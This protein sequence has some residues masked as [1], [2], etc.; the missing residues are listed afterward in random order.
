M[1]THMKVKVFRNQQMLPKYTL[2][3]LV[4]QSCPTLCDAIDGSLQGSPVPGILQARI[5]EWVAM[6]FSRGSSQPRGSNP[7]LLHCRQI[8][9]PLSYREV[10]YYQFFLLVDWYSKQE[11]FILFIYLT[12]LGLNLQHVGSSSLARD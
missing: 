2:Y 10:L 4:A 6:P 7:D 3:T 11:I 8:L 12:V 9:N 5:L 1:V